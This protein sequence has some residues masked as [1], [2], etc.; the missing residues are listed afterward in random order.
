MLSFNNKERARQQQR[1]AHENRYTSRSLD[2]VTTKRN[3]RVDAYLHTASRRIIDLLVGEGIG[4]LVIGKNPL[5]KQE[6]TMGRKNNQQFVQLPHARFIEQ[7][8]YKAHLVGIRVILQEESY[9]SKASFLDDDPIPSQP[10]R[11]T[12]LRSRCFQASV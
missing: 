11:P 7:L 2:R 4:T 9:T 5:W 6:V 1:L 8:T 12:L 10:M 3:R